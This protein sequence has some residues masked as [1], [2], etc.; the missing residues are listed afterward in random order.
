MNTHPHSSNAENARDETDRGRTETHP[1]GRAARLAKSG[2]QHLPAIVV[3][4]A[5]GAVAAWGHQSGWKVPAFGQLTAKEEAKAKEDWCDQ[6]NVPDSRCIKCHPELVGGNMKDW[7]PEHGTKESTCTLCHPEI[8]TTGVAGDWCPEHGIPETSCTLCHPEIAVKS[9]APASETGVTVS[10]TTA[11]TRPTTAPAAQPHAGEAVAQSQPAAVGKPAKNP[12]T[13]QTHTLR[14]QFA[15]AESVRKAGVR[16]AAV[17]ERPMA[18]TFNAVGEIDYNRTRLALISARVPGTAW[19]VE[20]EAGQRVLK[21]EVLALVDAAE[22]GRAKAELLAAHAAYDVKSKINTRLRSSA[23]SGFRTDAEVQ[24]AEAAVKEADIRVFNAQQALINL[25]L[26]AGTDDA[27]K[28]DRRSVQFLGLPKP[29]ADALDPK[30]T[31]AN[32]LPVVTPFDGVMI[33]RHVVAG[34]L[35]AL[36]KPLFEIADTSRMWV[37]LNLPPADVQRVVR[38]QDVTFQPDGARDQGAA[39]KISWISTAVDEQTRTLKVRAEVENPDGRLLAHTFGTARVTI[40]QTPNAIAVPDESIQ[41]EGCCHIVF[42]RLTED[43]FQVRKVKLGA[44]ASGFTEVAIGV[45]PGEVIASAG[46]QVL[47]A[48]LLKS[49]LGAGCCVE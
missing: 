36:D 2:L 47:K 16:V 41:W 1:A 44:R 49:A 30:S 32:L 43:I 17:V 31:T 40:R 8:L 45:L 18:A 12:K 37:T 20:K 6:H 7:C 34:E 11:A 24:E 25:G 48:E 13:C 23:E 35:V 46:S 10:A 27:A 22:V 29:L 26:S 9:E 33:A 38:G 14:V 42:V 28:P 3:F 19:R 15:S 4:L 39:G 5:L 21:G